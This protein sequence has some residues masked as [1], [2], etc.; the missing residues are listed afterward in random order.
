MFLNVQLRAFWCERQRFTELGEPTGNES[1]WCP[2]E[3]GTKLPDPS[4]VHYLI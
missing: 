2:C 3:K 4:N 1:P